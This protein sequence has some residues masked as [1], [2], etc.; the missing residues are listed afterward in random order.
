MADREENLGAILEKYMRGLSH[1]QIANQLEITKQKV[2][3]TLSTFR[4]D[5]LACLS[6][7]ELVPRYQHH[8]D[9]IHSFNEQFYTLMSE[10]GSALSNE[11][12]L[13]CAFYVAYGN[14]V[15][16]IKDSGLDVGLCADSQTQSIYDKNCLLRS[17]S[18]KR[19][20]NIQQEIRRL[21]LEKLEI[22][23]LTKDK[24]LAMHIEMIE[25]LKEEGNA[26]NRSNIVKLLDQVN[27][28]Q[29]NYTTKIVTGDLNADD[30]LDT[31]L[32][33]MEA[34]RPAE[35]YLEEIQDEYTE[36]D[37]EEG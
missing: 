16:A 37:N 1:Q 6:V 24:I 36:T 20:R 15:K 4:N 21:Q 2:D 19:K 8:S 12:M 30:I 9:T 31:Q 5:Y 33:I 34:G 13:Y 18:L 14:S 10:P 23:D 17:E 26:N 28:M 32:A 27:K 22:E 29:G 35:L 7:R 11:E 25:Q 3:Y